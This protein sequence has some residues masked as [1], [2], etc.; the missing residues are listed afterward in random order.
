M[1][2]K[3]NAAISNVIVYRAINISILQNLAAEHSYP[4]VKEVRKISSDLQSSGIRTKLKVKVNAAFS[5][6][7]V[8]RINISILQNSAA[9]QHNLYRRTLRNNNNELRSSGI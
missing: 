6:V 1:K 5:N 9:E 3:L 8:Y 7:V 4:Y 2:V